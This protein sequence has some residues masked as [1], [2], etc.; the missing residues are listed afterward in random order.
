MSIQ[1]GSG[2][3]VMAPKITGQLTNVQRQRQRVTVDAL[4]DAARRGMIE[5][6]LDVTMDDIADLAG[7][8]R[9]TAF[10]HFATRD[11]LL[12]AALTATYADYVQSLPAYTGGDCLALPAAPAP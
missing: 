7:V 8:G 11:D 2:G 12:C 1:A 6:G 9:R 4:I 3:S 5:H 10:R